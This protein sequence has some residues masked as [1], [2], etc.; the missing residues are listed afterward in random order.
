MKSQ[1]INAKLMK[2]DRDKKSTEAA[3]EGAKR[4]AEAQHKLLRQAKDDLATTRSQIKQIEQEGYDV[5][6]IDT[7]EAL[8]AKVMW[9]YRFYCLQVWNKALDQARV[10]ASSALRRAE[11]VYYSLAICTSGS[12]GSKADPVSSE[13]NEGKASPSKAPPAAYISSKES[14]PV[15][16]NEKPRDT[17]KEVAHDA[18]CLQFPPKTLQRRKRLF[19]A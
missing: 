17:T 12:S 5:G 7:E 14:G 19:R 8:R 11:N 13:A 15:E 18:P 4:Q 9:V 3:L 6:V 10:E 16:D 1:D 2:A